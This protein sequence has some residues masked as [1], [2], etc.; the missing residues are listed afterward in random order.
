MLAK[1]W[2][3]HPDR[4]RAVAAALDDATRRWIE[5]DPAW[6]EKRLEH[7]AEKTPV[8]T[9]PL[10]R[11]WLGRVG[12]FGLPRATVELDAWQQE[13]AALAADTFVQLALWEGRRMG[14]LPVCGGIRIC[15]GAPRRHPLK[16]RPCDSHPAASVS[17]PS[18]HFQ[19]SLSPL[20]STT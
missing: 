19:N 18:Q 17:R 11:A 13:G 14:K 5:R 8:R 6:L 2:Q 9:S 10:W 4:C 1:G 16:L 15:A 3:L 12:G 7:W 20:P